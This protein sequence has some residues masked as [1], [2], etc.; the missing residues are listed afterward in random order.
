MCKKGRQE[1][2]R[3]LLACLS[4]HPQ[5]STIPASV[6]SSSSGRLARS[7]VFFSLL[8]CIIAPTM[9]MRPWGSVAPAARR[10][11]DA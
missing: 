8:W 2:R 10:A 9:P 6:V 5:C 11:G 3:I 4:S 7:H 1:G